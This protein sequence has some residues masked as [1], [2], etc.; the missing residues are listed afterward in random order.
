MWFTSHRT[1]I[2]ARAR[3]RSR[4]KLHT[5]VDTGEVRGQPFCNWRRRCRRGRD[6]PNIHQRRLEKLR[7]LRA[8]CGSAITTRYAEPI[9]QSRRTS[10]ELAKSSRSSQ[11]GT[12]VPSARPDNRAEQIRQLA[13]LKIT[14]VGTSRP[15]RS[16]ARFSLKWRR[17]LVEDPAKDSIATFSLGHPGTSGSIKMSIGC[18]SRLVRGCA[19]QSAKT[20]E[21]QERSK[22][23]GWRGSYVSLLCVRFSQVRRHERKRG[24]GGGTLIP[25]DSGLCH[26]NPLCPPPSPASPPPPPPQL[27]G[28]L[29]SSATRE[30]N[31]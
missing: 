19:D 13:P 29:S 24:G 27:P 21:Y 2:K 6:L 15:R 7:I 10:R 17:A 5:A 20:S 25:R 9:V 14:R 28:G 3:A 30:R 26:I 8:P 16:F 18:N 1:H 22:F 23:A 11:R 31:S 12:S 4:R